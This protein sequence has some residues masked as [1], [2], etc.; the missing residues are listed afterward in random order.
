MLLHVVR[1]EKLRRD[2]ETRGQLEKNIQGKL[3]LELAWA[4]KCKSLEHAQDHVEN[5]LRLQTKRWE[6]TRK[7]RERVCPEGVEMRR[8][9]RDQVKMS[10]LIDMLIPS[11]SSLRT[12]L[13]P[14]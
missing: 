2:L 1:Q 7:E 14:L 5:T 6:H 9:A 13:G 8:L 11:S 4:G 12:F 3:K 10:I